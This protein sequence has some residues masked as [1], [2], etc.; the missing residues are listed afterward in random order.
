VYGAVSQANILSASRSMLSVLAWQALTAAVSAAI[1]ISIRLIGRACGSVLRAGSL[2]LIVRLRHR[3][4]DFHLHHL[5]HAEYLHFAAATA[6]LDIPVAV[7]RLADRNQLGETFGWYAVNYDGH[8][9]LGGWSYGYDL[10][11]H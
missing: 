7:R 6:E 1:R 3:M 9:V 10:T 4:P 2:L 5:Q 8:T 11:A